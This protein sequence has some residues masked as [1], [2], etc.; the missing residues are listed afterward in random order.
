[1]PVSRLTNPPCERCGAETLQHSDHSGGWKQCP[2]CGWMQ[3]IRPTPGGEPGRL[4]DFVQR[5]D[6]E[7]LEDMRREDERLGLRYADEPDDPQHIDGD[8]ASR[9]TLTEES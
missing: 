9:P 1:M 2:V 3:D 6:S 7:A 4:T 5:V 8:V